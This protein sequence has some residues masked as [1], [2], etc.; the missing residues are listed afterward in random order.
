MSRRSSRFHP[1]SA[2]RG[3]FEVTQMLRDKH[4]PYVINDQPVPPRRGRSGLGAAIPR[5]TL[6]CLPS[7]TGDV[8]A[9]Y[10]KVQLRPKLAPARFFTTTSASRFSVAGL[11]NSDCAAPGSGKKSATSPT[12]VLQ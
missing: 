12:V 6:P 3:R 4:K 9:L 2:A 1:G 5:A 7:P 10:T 8:Q 11:W